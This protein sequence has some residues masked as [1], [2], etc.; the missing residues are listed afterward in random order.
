MTQT[1][2]TQEIRV[3]II[4]VVALV[5]L[6]GGIIWGQGSGFKVNQRTITIRFPDASGV[7]PG[8]AVTLNGVRQGSVTSVRPFSDHVLITV[9]IESRVPLQRDASARI[10][11]AELMGG[12]RIA[13]VPGTSG[14]PL[15]SDAIIQGS[16]SGDP[17]ALLADAGQIGED[18][19][20]ALR[21]LDSSL[22]AVNRI[23]NE[24]AFRRRIENTLIN[25][26]SASGAVNSIAVENAHTVRS[27]LVNVD[28][29]ASDLRL[30]VQRSSPVLERTL[31][32]VEESSLEARSVINA[33]GAGLRVAD[34]LLRRLDTLAV[35]LRHGDGVIPMLL[36]DSAFAEEFRETIVATRELIEQT[37][38]R[39]INLN[40]GV[41]RR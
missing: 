16:V 24:P 33:A 14:A 2:R 17:S 12:K 4:S 9:L 13:I 31:A 19:R 5:A 18:A 7:E 22:A 35:L 20:T 11:L 40:V 34:T 37:R 27:A 15:P 3:G 30:L 1:S 41:G 28:A 32:G 6:I 25:L 26:E 36:G 10:E 21:R 8:A 23:V 39:G 29:A 38:R